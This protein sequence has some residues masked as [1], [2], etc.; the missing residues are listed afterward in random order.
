M[1]KRAIGLKTFDFNCLFF[2]WLLCLPFVPHCVGQNDQ[3]A[4]KEF[5]RLCGGQFRAHAGLLLQACGPVEPKG[6][7][8]RESKTQTV[9]PLRQGCMVIST[10]ILP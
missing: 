9:K 2:R 7:C 3:R 4:A 5:T 1:A 10:H 8:E 6:I